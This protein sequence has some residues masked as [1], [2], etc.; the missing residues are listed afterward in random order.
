VLTS[1]G[2]TKED[3]VLLRGDE[4]QRAQVRD[5]ISLERTLIVE[6]KSSNAFRAGNRATR[7]LP[8]PPWASRAATSRCR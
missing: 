2:R 1:P 5:L 4:V 3:D 7:I 8:S 6:S